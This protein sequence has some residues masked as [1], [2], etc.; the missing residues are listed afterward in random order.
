LNGVLLNKDI[1]SFRKSW[2]SK[3]SNIKVSP[4][5]LGLGK[6]ALVLSFMSADFE[7]K[8]CCFYR[9][10]LP[11]SMFVTSERQ[12]TMLE[13]EKILN[14]DAEMK[15]LAANKC[16]MCMCPV[17]ENANGVC[18]SMDLIHPFRARPHSPP[19]TAS[20]SIHACRHCSHVWTDRWR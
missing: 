15:Y 3:F 8:L 9:F 4:V 13:A 20:G 16:V 6:C 17:V 2:Q 12:K 10:L 1:N 7:S 11:V 19:Q 18:R 14:L 5:S